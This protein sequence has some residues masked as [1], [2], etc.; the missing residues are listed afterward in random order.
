MLQ[1]PST[2]AIRKQGACSRKSLRQLTIV[3]VDGT[4][5][6]ARRMC[7]ALCGRAATAACGNDIAI[8]MGNKD[9]CM[10]ARPLQPVSLEPERVARAGASVF[11]PL[12]AQSTE[13][14]CSTAEAVM[15]ALEELDEV[16][17]SAHTSLS[18][19]PAAPCIAATKSDAAPVCL[20]TAYLRRRLRYALKCMVDRLAL[21]SGRT[22]LRAPTRKSR[23]ARAAQRCQ[24]ATVRAFSIYNSA[25]TFRMG[26]SIP[27]LSTFLGT[28]ALLLHR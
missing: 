7:A 4:W 21:Q 26:H 23:W 18:P 10:L 20:G 9:S 2:R 11:A 3:V 17:A 28:E 6:Q 14:R 8:N 24:P 25:Y 12:R 13:S 22:G 27:P 15:H 16:E 1:A 19:A 5:S